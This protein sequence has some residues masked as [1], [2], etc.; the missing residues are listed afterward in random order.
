M[1]FRV[2]VPLLF[3]LFSFPVT[4]F[5]NVS[6]EPQKA[7]NQVEV[8]CD[9]ARWETIKNLKDVDVLDTFISNCTDSRWLPLAHYVKQTL[10][11]DQ[12]RYVTEET[13]QNTQH[14]TDW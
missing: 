7:E 1:R 14:D 8:I 2:V 10:K 12:E 13:S 9:D 6:K 5:S 3:V 11:E 4:I